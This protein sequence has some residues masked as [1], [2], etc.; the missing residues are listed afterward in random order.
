MSLWVHRRPVPSFEILRW[1][2][3]YNAIVCAAHSVCSSVYSL[4]LPQAYVLD[5]PVVCD[6]G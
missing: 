3:D 1:R 4:L 6:P 5:P 2:V